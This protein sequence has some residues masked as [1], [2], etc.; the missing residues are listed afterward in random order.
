MRSAHG[1]HSSTSW[2]GDHSITATGAWARYA[3]SLW[4]DSVE[5][6]PAAVMLDLG[7]FGVRR[8]GLIHEI[9]V[10]KLLAST[11]PCRPHERQGGRPRGQWTFADTGMARKQR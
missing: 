6:V 2:P 11:A 5:G 1:F 10:V 4:A 3:F 9:D 7:D 8:N